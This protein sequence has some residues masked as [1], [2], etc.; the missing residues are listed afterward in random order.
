MDRRS[1]NPCRAAARS[2]MR[3]SRVTASRASGHIGGVTGHS[4]NRADSLRRMAGRI[5]LPGTCDSGSSITS[6][7][8]SVDS[9]MSLPAHRRAGWTPGNGIDSIVG[10]VV[11]GR[12]MGVLASGSKSLSLE[13]SENPVAPASR[14]CV[15]ADEC[16]GE[17]PV[18]PVSDSSAVFLPAAS[19]DFAFA[20]ARK[21]ATACHCG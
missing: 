6:E 7:I 14:S 8:E 3:R 21:S 1:P 9:A 12:A 13:W 10:S 11:I 2:T 15:S 4:T 5:E 18:P 17:T 19:P 20:R 16:T